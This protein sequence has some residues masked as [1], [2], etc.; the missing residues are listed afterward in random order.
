MTSISPYFTRDAR[1]VL[2]GQGDG[3]V[4]FLDRETRTTILQWPYQPHR[5]PREV[6]FSPDNAIA[7]VGGHGLNAELL[8]TKT[9]K[10]IGAAIPNFGDVLGFAPDGKTAFTGDLRGLWFWDAGTGEF[11]RGRL[12][13][14]DGVYAAALSP[15]GRLVLTGSEFTA[16]LWEIESN[17]P[18][19]KRLQH[20]GLVGCVAFSP[21]GA[22]LATGSDDRTA[23]L[24]DQATQEPIG[25]PLRHTGKVLAVQFKPDGRFLLTGD[26]D[27]P[28]RLWET[29]AAACVKH[30]LV[31]PEVVNLVAFSS[32][33]KML[34]TGCVDD[35]IRLWDVEK[36]ALIQGPSH[37]PGRSRDAA[38]S[39]DSRHYVTAGHDKKLRLWDTTTGQCICESAPLPIGPNFIKFTPDGKRIL[40]TTD[41]GAAVVVNAATLSQV[42]A[43]KLA[44]CRFEAVGFSPAE[45]ALLA[46]AEDGSPSSPPVSDPA[47]GPGSA[48]VS[49]PAPSST[50][51]RVSDPAETA[52]RRSPNGPQHNSTASNGTHQ[53]QAPT[54]STEDR[55]PWLAPEIRSAAFSDDGTRATTCSVDGT[56]WLWDAIT[57]ERLVELLP[58]HRGKKAI[59]FS[60]DGRTV[61]AIYGD[62][63]A[64][65]LDLVTG[66]VIGA[67]LEHW[68]ERY[69]AAF[70]PDGRYI[71]TISRTGNVVCVREIPACLQGKDERIVVWTQVITG[72]EMDASGYVNVL[73]AEGWQRR[74]DHLENLGGPPT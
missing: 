40:G 30:S 5:L 61:L 24:W 54:R 23:R 66:T 45:R 32:H 48:R 2:T 29:P 13:E 41:A 46:A 57:G 28:A 39:P 68:A 38:V 7:I 37:H 67:P 25:Q 69:R 16:A 53:R 74:R 18:L 17:K 72:L 44:N 63:R 9:G 70:S 11:T 62:G 22:I 1:V 65:L 49:G 14:E 42:R 10:R 55:P 34:L 8:N 12:M 31:H 19:G 27:S 64:R 71:A 47:P 60:P 20:G 58:N 4:R 21:D 36:G 3:S 52:D 6:A 50:S 59:V 33:G 35:T 51:V 73:D 26:E 56:L 15:D 43:A